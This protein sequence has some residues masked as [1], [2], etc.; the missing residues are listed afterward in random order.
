MHS[1]F[2]QYIERTKYILF[3]CCYPSAS[4]LSL[5][6]LVSRL[7]LGVFTC[8]ENHGSG[9]KARKGMGAAGLPVEMGGVA[10]PKPSIPGVPTFE[11]A[12]RN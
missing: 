9:V 7:F 3:G 6:F 1:T 11:H 4:P 5:C 10:Q 12:V 2:A 8:L